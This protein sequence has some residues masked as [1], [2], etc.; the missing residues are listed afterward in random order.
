MDATFAPFQF[1]PG[2]LFQASTL[3]ELVFN[4]KQAEDFPEDNPPINSL[5]GLR[6]LERLVVLIGMLFKHDSTVVAT[7]NP[8]DALLPP[9]LITL[10]LDLDE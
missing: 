9:S 4:T 3:K 5:V 1:L 2:L 6:A 7:Q 10:E 8:L